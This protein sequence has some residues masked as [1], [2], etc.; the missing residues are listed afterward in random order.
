MIEMRAVDIVQPD[1]CYLGGISRVTLRVCRMAAK[2]PACPVTP[3]CANLSMV[4]LVHHAPAAR[5]PER[6]QV[7]GVLH[8]GRPTTIPWQVGA[9]YFETPYAHRRWPCA[10]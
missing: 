10:S 7:P 1:I 6:R 2:L 9:L 5:D 3:H 8:R 4:T